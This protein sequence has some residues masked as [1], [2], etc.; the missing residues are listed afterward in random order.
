[1]INTETRKVSEI[2]WRED[3]YPRFEP[4][5]SVIQ[6]YAEDVE[7]YPPVEINQHNELI[8]GYHRWTAHKKANV[9][10][11]AVI[12]TETTSD[13]HFARLAMS[14]N[15][16]HGL[17]ISNA[18]KK[19]WL[20][21]W[22]TGESEEQKQELASDMGVSLR[23]VKRWTARK[24]KDLKVKRQRKAFDLWLA[25]ETLEDIAEQMPINDDTVG[26]YVEEYR[27]SDN[28]HKLGIFPDHA[29]DPNWKPPIYNVWKQQT[30][31]IELSHSGN[32][33]ASFLD[34][35]LYLYT[36]PFSIVVDPFAGSGSTIDVCKKRLR[37]YW[38]SD[39]LP[40]VERR[41]IRTW[42][43]LEG[44]PPLHK[45]WGDVELLYLD[46][47]YWK[48]VEGD[49]SDDAEDLANM[50]L[51]TF[52]ETLS[53]FISAC[54]D[55]MHNGYI[56]MLMQPTQWRAPE[57][58]VIDHAFAVRQVV[59][60]PLEI[61]IQCPYESQQANAQQVNWAKENKR[62]LEIGRTITVWRIDKGSTNAG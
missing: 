23:T 36:D 53:Q 33:E 15:A 3:L 21:S 41:D 44:P 30:K 54:A 16:Q 7:Q 56:A 47:P 58:Q 6:R 25:C 43:I 14:R 40:I 35:L 37:R 12:V 61:T 28:W 48:Q 18:E 8:D 24:D 27:K 38:V 52:H 10:T 32:S 11:I 26:N 60:L 5:P 42:D 45:R 62:L 19:D 4:N 55:K 49:Y 59:N 51:G 1:M 22:Y 13:R 20:L 17:H 29:A 46:P 39:R 2:V 31:S 34:R 57:R 9:E 50:E